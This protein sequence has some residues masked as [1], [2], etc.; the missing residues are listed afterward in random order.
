MNISQ[1]QVKQIKEI[2]VME[3]DKQVLESKLLR[4]GGLIK[5]VTALEE[6][7]RSQLNSIEV[8]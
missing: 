5:Y 2:V 3:K 8:L 7:L 6:I 4:L 1:G